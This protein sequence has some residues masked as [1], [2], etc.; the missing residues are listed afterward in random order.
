MQSE[1]LI[2]NLIYF[3]AL[4]FNLVLGVLVFLKNTREKVNRLFLAAIIFTSL[5]LV[6]LFLFYTIESHFWV[7]WLGRFNFAIAL[8]IFYFL[9][10]FVIV[11]PKKNII[12]ARQ[13]TISLG[14][15]TL[16]FTLITFLTPFV[17]QDEIILGP[18]QRETIYGPLFILYILHY[19]IFS[20]AIIA[21]LFRK[22][23]I[24]RTEREKNQIKHII[25]GLFLAL[26]FVFTTNIFLYSFGPA[27][28]ANFGPL[29]TVIF[30]GFVVAAILRHH[31][32]GFRVI[33]VEILVGAIA[34]IMLIQTV[35]A[36]TFWLRVINII[37]FL[38]FLIFGYLLIMG[39]LKEIKY[40]E[41]IQTAY[42]ELKKLDKA[43][44]EFI[45][46]ASH[47]LRTPLSII[48]G[49]L[50]M[51]LDGSYGRISEKARQKMLDVFQSNE[52][53]IK[54]SNELLN[55]SKID[56]GKMDVSLEKSDI[57][58]IIKSCYQELKP[59]ADCK[60]LEMI[61]QAPTIPLPPIKID[62]FKIRQVLLNLI[63]NAIKY[64]K[65]G[66]VEIKAE[67]KDDCLQIT[68]SDTGEGL[69]KEEQSNIFQSFMRGMAGISYW[70]EGAG[71]GL[72]LAKKYLEL[73]QGSIKVESAG[74]GRGT[75]FYVRLPYQE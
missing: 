45:S 60:K 62:S 22:I 51:L 8:P 61:W 52:R 34:L 32:F 5:W 1:F 48:K 11:F 26:T 42:N 55:I 46:M 57:V 3:A 54:V 20:F 35:A 38:L 15:W 49:Y 31:L 27:E 67:K 13:I 63:D 56:L 28:A 9:L 58:E 2:R 14:L 16:L 50:S 40:R 74:K 75:T 19:L 71:L 59:E 33:L 36:Q 39:V 41:E 17:V 66:K 43:K 30:S 12:L 69:S 10:E 29:G 24:S 47:Q 37:A 23:K 64:T 18:G 6:S 65:Q 73:H 72:Y 53:L 44:S 21:I 68:V 7:L 4:G 25:I 70:T